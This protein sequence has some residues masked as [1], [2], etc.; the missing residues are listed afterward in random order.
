MKKLAELLIASAV[1]TP[2]YTFAQDELHQPEGWSYSVGLGA[3]YAP[4][5]MGDDESRLSFIPNISIAYSDT[6]FASL[7]EGVGYH[8]IN[9]EHWQI[10]PILKYDFGR[11]EDSSNMLSTGDDS[12]DLIGLGDVDGTF[13]IGAYVKYNINPITINLE[14]RQGIDGHEGVVGEASIKYSGSS[15]IYGQPLFYSFGPEIKYTDG[16]YNKTF[17]SVNALQSAASGLAQYDAD[18]ATLSYGI[19]G[20]IMIPHTQHISTILFANYTHLGDTISDSSLIVQ[21]G[22][23]EQVMVGFLVDYRF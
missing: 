12:I 9:N 3:F 4:T 14:L 18:E 11:D 15:D 6:F 22:E 2:F 19:G 10:G 23:E 21:R 1:M 20:N 13:E 5:Y 17:F 8:I 16:H 7:G